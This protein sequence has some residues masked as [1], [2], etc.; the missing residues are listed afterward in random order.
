MIEQQG[1]ITAGEG[2]GTRLGCERL[3]TS[4]A[5]GSTLVVL[6]AEWAGTHLFTQRA[7][8]IAALVSK[9]VCVCVARCVCVCV[10]VL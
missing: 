9:C 7:A 2:L 4:V 1:V 8:L 6:A 10:C 5:G 3:Q